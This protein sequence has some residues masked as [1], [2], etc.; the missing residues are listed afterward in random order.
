MAGMDNVTANIDALVANARKVQDGKAYGIDHT[1]RLI[2]EA[3]KCSFKGKIVDALVGAGL[4]RPGS[5]LGYFAA[6]LVGQQSLDLIRRARS[7]PHHRNTVAN[8]LA[9]FEH[10]ETEGLS[11]DPDLKHDVKTRI[12]EEFFPGMSLRALTYG[13]GT[14][15]GRILSLDEAIKAEVIPRRLAAPQR[16]ADR[17]RSG[18]ASEAMTNAHQAALSAVYQAI[19]EDTSGEDGLHGFKFPR[20]LPLSGGQGDF[21]YQAEAL[22]REFNAA[23][24]HVRHTTPEG[25]DADARVSTFRAAYLGALQARFEAIDAEDGMKLRMDGRE[26]APLKKAFSA[27][28]RERIGSEPFRSQKSRRIESTGEGAPEK[29]GV[30]FDGKTERTFD[31]NHPS[32]VAGLESVDE[33]PDSSVSQLE[34]VDAIREQVADAAETGDHYHLELLA[35]SLTR[36]VQNPE[37][38]PDAVR[39]ALAAKADPA[40]ADHLDCISAALAGVPAPQRLDPD[41]EAMFRAVAPRMRQ[42]AEA[43]RDR[44]DNVAARPEAHRDF[45][46]DFEEAFGHR[47]PAVVQKETRSAISEVRLK[48]MGVLDRLRRFTV[49]Q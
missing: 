24:A 3:L 16:A 17:I 30:R 28:Q 41:V 45:Y 2:G 7:D 37:S 14:T 35:K 12:R 32:E 1:G 27:W 19:A 31:A 4:A 39:A 22:V 20:K 43:E 21:R 5:V 15:A 44:I 36:I 8:V 42:V 11:A 6:G 18:E 10:Y 34:A 47:G 23:T 25:Q 48:S 46:A 38:A 9:L 40:F 29:R 26:S 33:V 49:Q 13:R